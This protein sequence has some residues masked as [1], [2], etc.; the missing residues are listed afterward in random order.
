MDPRP[1]VAPRLLLLGPLP[2]AEPRRAAIVPA[3][4]AAARIEGAIVAGITTRRAVVIVDPP[5][6][7]VRAIAVGHAIGINLS[8]SVVAILAMFVAGEGPGRREQKRAEDA[9]SESRCFHDVYDVDHFGLFN[10]TL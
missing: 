7:A 6:R 5:G 8:E 4:I 2:A 3:V 10:W 1:L 9:A